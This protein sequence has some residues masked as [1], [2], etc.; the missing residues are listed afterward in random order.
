[1]EIFKDGK[2][3]THWA[4]D[5][6]TETKIVNKNSKLRMELAPG[7]GYTAHLTLM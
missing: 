5:Y 4:E 7:G 3:A 2:N 1:M 6:S